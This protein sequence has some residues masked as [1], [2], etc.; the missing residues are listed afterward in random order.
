MSLPNCCQDKQDPRDKLQLRYYQHSLV[1]IGNS[2]ELRFLRDG[3]TAPCL[4]PE[5][6]LNRRACLLPGG[7]H[8]PVPVPPPPT[9]WPWGAC[10]ALLA[11]LGYSRC[12][13]LLLDVCLLFVGQLTRVRYLS[14]TLLLLPHSG[15][16]AVSPAR[17]RPPYG[18]LKLWCGRRMG[19]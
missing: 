11:L 17:R 14:A 5:S 8:L 18:W 15:C 6:Y 10:Q 16:S 13:C 2:P 1:K 3:R 7:G 12:R 19:S 4:G 9:V